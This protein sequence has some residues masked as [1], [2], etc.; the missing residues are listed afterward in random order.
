M[1]WS[2]GHHELL[3]AGYEDCGKANLD[4]ELDPSRSSPVFLSE[5]NIGPGTRCILAG[6]PV[7]LAV[8][9]MRKKSSRG[10]KALRT[11]L[12]SRNVYISRKA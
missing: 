5:R 7:L 9:A 4:K 12:V 8:L 11:L 6:A 2:A 1:F 3:W 10:L